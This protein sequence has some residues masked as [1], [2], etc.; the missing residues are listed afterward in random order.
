MTTEAN[1]WK[2]RNENHIIYHHFVERILTDFVEEFW[3][4]YEFP[5]FVVHSYQ[6]EPLRKNENAQNM[7]IKSRYL[8]ELTIYDNLYPIYEK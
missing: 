1:R 3:F 5:I 7:V 6:F 2:R 8:R 4:S